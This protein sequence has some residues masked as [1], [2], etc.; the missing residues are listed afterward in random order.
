MVKIADNP[1]ILVDGSAYLYRAYHA[2][3]KLTNRDGEPTGAIYG[4]VN[5][6]KSLLIRYKPNDAAIIFDAQGNLFRNELFKYYKFHRPLMPHNLRSQ[7]EPLYKIIKAM[8]LSLLTINDVE[9]DD[10]IG[11]IAL[12][13]AYNGRSVLIS[14]GDKDMAQLVSSKICLINTTSNTILGP[15]DIKSKFGVQ[16]TLII[17]YLAL[18]GDIS[19]NIPGVP[20]IGKKTAKI[21]LNTL[22]NL[23]ILYQN[24]DRI[25]SLTLRGAKNIAMKL[26]KNQDIAFLSYQLAKIKTDVQ[27]ELSYNSL[28]INDLDTKTLI[29]LFQRYE[30]K[31]WINDI[32]KKKWIKKSKGTIFI[33][34]IPPN[35]HLQLKAKIPANLNLQKNHLIINE[36]TQLD[37]WIDNIRTAGIFAFN[38]KTDGLDILNANLIGLCFAIKPGEAAYLPIKHNYSNVPY[39]LDQNRVLSILKPLLEDL[40]IRKIGQNLKFNYS[41]LQRYNIKLA[42][43]FLDT[44]LE[45]YVIDS[46]A[47]NH[48]IDSL[49]TRFLHYNKASFE[50]IAGKGKN[51]LTFNQINI[52]LAAAYV[53]EEL[54][55]IFRLHE[56]M[57]PQIK[58]NNHLK[59]I[60]EEIEI[61]LVPVLSR[62]EQTGVL[63]DKNILATHSMDLT[64]NLWIIAQKAYSITE[65]SFNF[66]SIKQLQV[67]LYEKQKLPILKKT[68]KGA[69]STN[70]EV[71][72][73]LALNY[74]LPKLILEYRKL[75]KLK[76]T[77]TDK[78][79]LMIN[80]ISKR[81]HTSYHQAITTTGRLSS[82]SPNLQNIPVRS[83]EGRRIRQA[84]IA[85]T[86]MLI[87]AADYSQIELRIMAHLSCDKGLIN[88]FNKKQDIHC[89]TAAEVFGVSLDKVTN[90]Q[91]RS[92]K[93]INFGLIYGMNTFSLAQHL[94]IPHS[95]A[96]KYIKFYFKRYPGILE[97][98]ERTRKQANEY[99]YIST[100]DGR[101]FY[102]PDIY[103]QNSVRQKRAERA[104]INATMQGTAAD[105]IKRAMISIDSWLQKETPPVRMIMQVHDELV[106][107]VRH[108]IIKNISTKIKFIMEGCFSLNVPLKVEVG[109][110][111]NWDQAH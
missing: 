78:L 107:E 64:K 1:L 90:D 31:D 109:V 15:E 100:I 84:F 96:Q 22:G 52:N 73:Q 44:M 23:K 54:N 11:T 27:L 99:G 92:A 83:K 48:D 60:F 86:N 82:S 67:I 49:V 50:E 43:I 7:I 8:G 56:K 106:F 46:T 88:A 74:P 89:V 28:K 72:I 10:V 59:K 45:S 30:F 55:I 93:I 21:L 16:P 70:E 102:L 103:S 40:S 76:S 9:A 25:T 105:I 75:A 94:S 39:Q 81:I 97:Y 68:P 57:W 71:L 101:R 62:I 13:A 51:K 29:Q 33:K 32:R 41:I 14:T 104:A 12:E 4:V 18:I 5:M 6:L 58:Q 65:E 17:D 63:I 3:P 53:T 110:G 87:M 20:G 79:P 47:G 111:I 66:Y 98:I 24:L 80:S 91:R 26:E 42:G 36:I 85:P 34:S 38:I 35:K 69:P 2:L 95:E 37:Q 19:D 61:P 77:Y 108:D